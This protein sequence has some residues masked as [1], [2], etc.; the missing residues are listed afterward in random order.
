MNKTA[1]I[2]AL[3]VLAAFLPSSVLNAAPVV[4]CVAGDGHAGLEIKI[5]KQAHT[6]VHPSD[7]HHGHSI[8]SASTHKNDHSHACLDYQLISSIGQTKSNDIDAKA[9]GDKICWGV[10]TKIDHRNL[11][12][13]A[14][15]PARA[16]PDQLLASPRLISIRTMM[17]R[18]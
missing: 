10:E 3:L 6:H 17:L 7:A 2:I 1:K 18:L 12:R 13:F 14:A 15:K 16:P 4:W 5:N 9:F 11:L 8:G